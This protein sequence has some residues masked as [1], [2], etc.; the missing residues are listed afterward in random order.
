MVDRKTD[1]PLGQ[2]GNDGEI[3]PTSCLTLAAEA[4]AEGAGVSTEP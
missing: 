1:S 2:R 4:A 3:T